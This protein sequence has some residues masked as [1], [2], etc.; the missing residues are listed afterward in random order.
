[1][2]RSRID[3]E[4]FKRRKVLIAAIRLKYALLAEDEINE[5]LEAEQQEFYRLVGRGK[6]P[7][8]LPASTIRP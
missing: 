7:A 6:L 3:Q 8:A 2:K 5:T 4:W 1:M